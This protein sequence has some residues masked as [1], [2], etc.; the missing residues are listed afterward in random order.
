MVFTLEGSCKEIA[1]Q[2]SD[3][4]ISLIDKLIYRIGHINEDV[5]EDYSCILYDC[6]LCFCFCCLGLPSVFTTF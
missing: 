2:S 5:S 4:T 6:L 3:V 1:D